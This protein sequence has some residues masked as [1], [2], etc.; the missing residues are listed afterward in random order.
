MRS[1]VAPGEPLLEATGVTKRFGGLA[2][3]D[4]VDVTIRR[5]EILG[6]LGP[7]GAGKTTF[8][9]CISGLVKPTS[10]RIL[11]ENEDITRLPGHEI[12]RRGIARTF[13]VVKPLRHLTV[14]EN[15]SIGAMFGAGGRGR[16]AA[17]ARRRAEEVLT[18]VGLL[19]RAR[20]TAGVLTIPDLKRLELARALA[21]DPKLLFLDEVMAGL[22]PVE[23]ESAMELLRQINRDG[24]TLFVIEHVMKAILGIS[25]RIVVLHFG[26]KI[27]EGQPRNVVEDPRVVEAYLGER[28][29]KRASPQAGPLAGGPVA[30]GDARPAPHPGRLPPGEGELLQVRGVSSGY[31]GVRALWDVSLDVRPGE[32]VALVGANGAGKTTL[33][34]TISRLLD[35]FEGTIRFRGKDVTKASAAEVVRAGLVHVPEGRRLFAG[36]TV[37]ENLLQGAYPRRDAREIARDL[38][39]VY[40]LMPRLAERA[41]QPGGLLSG[42]EQQMCAIG[43]GLMAR[44]RLLVID[45]LSLGLAPVVVDGLLDLL[46]AIKREGTAVLM[47]EQDVQVALEHADRGY[48]MESGRLVQE[49]PAHELLRDPRIRQAYLGL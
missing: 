23:V 46:S 41:E 37:R 42:G 3:L 35:A 17:Q 16:T 48:V 15:V 11:F 36:L 32:L 22:N 28:Y 27:A 45:E 19:A 5:G 13:Q 39:R 21:M 33:L 29:A 20:D 2:A 18:R 47:V 7:N 9:N 6:V 26:R 4:G 34:L 12:G 14:L 24:V 10:G 25:D 40:S 49:S 8:V 38:E 1:V 44:P 43:R 30:R 31:G